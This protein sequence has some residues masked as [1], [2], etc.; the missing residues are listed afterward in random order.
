VDTFLRLAAGKTNVSQ[1]FPLG[2]ITCV[3]HSAT[4]PTDVTWCWEVRP[5]TGFWRFVTA[6]AMAARPTSRDPTGW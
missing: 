3:N 2:L 6:L 1:V 5:P 4:D